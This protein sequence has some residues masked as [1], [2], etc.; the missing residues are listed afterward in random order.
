MGYPVGTFIESLPLLHS[1]NVVFHQLGAA[2]FIDKPFPSH[3]LLSDNKGNNKWHL[4][5]TVVCTATYYDPRYKVECKSYH[6][7]WNS[8]L[9]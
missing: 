8:D 1:E 3:S 7:Y 5:Q 2:H 4:L 9:V 6:T